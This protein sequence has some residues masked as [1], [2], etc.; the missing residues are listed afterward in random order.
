MNSTERGSASFPTRARNSSWL[1][2]TAV[3]AA[4]TGSVVLPA[5]RAADAAEEGLQ[6]VTVTGSRI[7]RRDLTAP[8]PIVTV[9]TQALDNSSTVAVES[10]LQQLPQFVPGGNQFVSGAQAGAAQT[11]G[12]ATLNLRGLGS[13]RNLV[14]LD[15]RRLQPANATLAIDVNTIPQAALQG[16]EVITGGASAVYGPDA[17]AGVVNFILKKDFEGLNVDTQFGTTE[18]GDGAERRVSV[19]MGMNG[20]GGRGNIMIGVDWTKRDAVYQR[21]RSFYVNGWRDPNNPGGDFMEQPTYVGT[22]AG[23]IGAN[24]PTQAAICGIFNLAATCTAPGTSSE[25][26]FNNDGTPFVQGVI[27]LPNGTKVGGLGYNGPLGSLTAGRNTMVNKLAD[28][29]LDEKYTTQYAS[30]PLERHSL[31]MRGRF[32]ITDNTSAFLQANYTNNEVLTRGNLAPAITTWAVNVPRDSRTL[33]AALNTLLNSRANPAGPW[34]LYQVLDYYGVLQSTN[35]SNVWQAMAGLQGKMPIK[36]WTWEAYY[37]TGKT[38]TLAETPTP[39]LQRYAMLI[40]APNFGKNAN[41]TVPPTGVL[42]GRGYTLKCTSGLP[43]FQEFKPSQDCLN[44]METRDRQVTDLTQDIFEANMQGGAFSLPAGEARFAAGVSYRKND[45]RFDPGYPVEQILDNPIGLFASNGTK[46]STNVKEVYGELLAPVIKNLDLELGYRL[47]DFNTAGTASTYKALFTWKAL[48]QVSFRGGY[49]YATRAPNTA[50]LYTGQTLLVVPFPDGDPCSVSTRSPWGNLPPGN[51]FSPT[52]SNP[53]YLK[54]QA[55]CRAI[56]G[57]STSGF[58]T[59]TFNTPNGPNGFTRA[60]PP[61][62]PLEIEAT[63]GNPKVGPETAKTFTLGAV[64][65]EPFGAK[66]LT[67]TVDAYRIKVLDAIAPVSSITAYNNCFNF[68]KTSNPTYS[69]TNP[70]CQL[71]Q[72]NAVTGD[73]AQVLALYSNL[74]TIETQGV[75]VTAAWNHDLG[76]GVFGV[77]ATLSYLD[78]Y[79][80]Q[81]DTASKQNDA[82]GTLDQGGQF[83]YRLLTNFTYKWNDFNFGLQWRHLPSVESAAKAIST[84]TTQQ[85]APSYDVFGLTGSYSFGRYT[86]RAGVDNVLDQAPPSINAIPGGDT[87]SDTTNPSYYDVLGRRYFVGLK[88][89]F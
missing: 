4:I 18:H 20:A 45:F 87:N 8:S 50:E 25:L 49:N 78:Y 21:D 29:S 17:L 38:S 24:L 64:L 82:T 26:R 6:E 44:S 84:T 13:N 28:G 30:T 80:Y 46:G 23:G 47:S 62:F 63:Q 41:I 73:R 16:V 48:D 75:D 70:F 36:D 10:V 86:L 55:L 79:K 2:A 74:G 76:P 65:T 14:L 22:A 7:Q 31:F 52:P 11:P 89:K 19:L 35:T 42:G 57:N 85:G 72:R 9:G 51:T 1:V 81:P 56:I 39:S 69:I 83:D 71:I 88:A 5:A 33:P 43:V 37:S 12:A 61:F 58:D 77:N 32:D 34:V 54:V 67:V 53:D 68:N 3:A 59:Q 27:T 40:A 15:G 66:N 60:N